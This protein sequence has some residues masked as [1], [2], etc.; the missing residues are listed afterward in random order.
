MSFGDLFA[1][2]RRQRKPIPIHDHGG[3]E[4]RELKSITKP[5]EMFMMDVLPGN[6]VVGDPASMD[7]ATGPYSE[8]RPELRRTRMGPDGTPA[9][10]NPDF[11]VPDMPSKEQLF[12]GNPANGG[13]AYRPERL[14][15]TQATRPYRPTPKNK[16]MGRII[17][18]DIR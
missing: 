6:G 5:S 18:G 13:K 3:A 14:Q 4:T 9:Q 2:L 7:I 11:T 8:P 1:L 16:R 15:R 10:N 17:K 12:G